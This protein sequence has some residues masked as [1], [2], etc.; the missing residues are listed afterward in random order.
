MKYKTSSKN[1][2]YVLKVDTN[3]YQEGIYY[4]LSEIYYK[5]KF[6][7]KIIIGIVYK[8]EINLNSGRFSNF[9]IKKQKYEVQIV[10]DNLLHKTL[11]TTES[12]LNELH[13][14]AGKWSMSVWITRFDSSG[15]TI[16]DLSF[17][18]ANDAVSFRLSLS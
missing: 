13:H 2:F 17:E 14:T 1:H 4:L 16:Y 8:S 6:L 3:T 11:T 5:S 7:D 9:T 12:I 18:D 10:I 15:K